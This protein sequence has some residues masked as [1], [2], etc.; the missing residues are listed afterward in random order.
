MAFE[1]ARSSRQG[2]VDML[3]GNSGP[4][5]S[6]EAWNDFLVNS[7]TGARGLFS[8]LIATYPRY[9][10]WRWIWSYR[11]EQRYLEFMQTMIDSARDAQKRQA[12]LRLPVL[13]VT[14]LPL[15]ETENTANWN[16]MD[17]MTDG[18]KRFVVRA[19]RAQTLV[20]MVAAAIALERF[21]LSRHSYP[22]DLASLAPDFLLAVPIDCMDG[23][24]LRY[25]L[26]R[27]GTFLLY[28]VGEDGIDNDGDPTPVEGRNPGFLSGRD[29]VWPRAA[30]EEEVQAYEA[31]QSKPRSGF[32]R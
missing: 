21:R 3:G 11:D 2:L 28:S 20:N 31:D 12:V 22:P 30:T 15:Q 17:S 14:S 9:Y 6:G 25:R 5:S 18:I 4:K 24:D 29:W 1:S 13:K 32:K 27:D 26:N 19:M 8:S 16:V 23:H 10:G 7:R